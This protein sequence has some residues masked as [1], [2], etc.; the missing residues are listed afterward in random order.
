MSGGRCEASQGPIGTSRGP[1]ALRGARREMIP[2]RDRTRLRRFPGVTL[3]LIA[4]NLAVFAWVA[5]RIA[6]GQEDAI[7]RAALVPRELLR[8]TDIPRL[9]TLLTSMFLHGDIAHLAGNLWYLWV[10]GSGV[11]IAMGGMRYLLFY[12]VA[13]VVASLVHVASAPV[14]TVP[15]I[16]ASGAIAGVLGAYALLFPRARIR[17]LLPVVPF[18]WMPVVRTPALLFLLAWFVLQWIG[19]TSDSGAGIAWMA[20]I[21]GFICGAALA[22]S[23]A[24]RRGSA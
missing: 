2:L 14:S 10:F 19:A 8:K 13:G 12:L 21:G 7:L 3:L 23:F 1:A 9:Q 16:G 11:E 15:L 5:T 24:R 20:H 6:A 4:A 18:L 17:T 22:L